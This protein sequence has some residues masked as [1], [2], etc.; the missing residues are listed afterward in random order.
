ML[1]PT[2]EESVRPAIVIV[3]EDPDNFKIVANEVRKRYGTDYQVVT[4]TSH[5]AATRNLEGLRLRD[6]PVA[7]ILATYGGQEQRG[8]S[9][10]AQTRSLH[11]RAKRVVVIVWGDFETARPILAAPGMWWR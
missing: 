2:D 1:G 8:I 10:L 4:S 11:P 9:F 6:V 3:S 7:L 5:S